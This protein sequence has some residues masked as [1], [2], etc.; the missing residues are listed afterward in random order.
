MMALIM[1]IVAVV[2]T[3]GG[4]GAALAFNPI[5]AVVGVVAGGFVWFWAKNFEENK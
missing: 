5:A 4:I 1:K 3:L 2:L